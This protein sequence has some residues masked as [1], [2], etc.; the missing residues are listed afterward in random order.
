M[1]E[2][3]DICTSRSARVEC[4]ADI[5]TNNYRDNRKR[6]SEGQIEGLYLVEKFK[7]QK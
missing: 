7:G 2:M 1:C 5:K 6:G 3:I 4:A